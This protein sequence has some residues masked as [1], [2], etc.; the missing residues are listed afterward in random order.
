M[1]HGLG[2]R[3]PRATSASA[4]LNDVAFRRLPPIK[5]AFNAAQL[6]IAT[7]AAG[8]VYGALPTVAGA[9]LAGATLLRDQQ[10]ARRPSVSSLAMGVSVRTA[11]ERDT[12]KPMAIDAD[13]PVAS[14]RS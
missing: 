3:A 2:S 11:L 6:V 12:L 10:S 9:A 1:I 4:S 8:W 7:A 5:V 14:R 13:A